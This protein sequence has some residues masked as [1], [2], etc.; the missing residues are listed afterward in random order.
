MLLDGSGS[1]SGDDWAVQVNGLADAVQD[2]SCFPQ[3]G[4]VELSVIQFSSSTI[5]HLDPTIV[6]SGN[7]ATVVAAIQDADD[8]Q[9]N[10][11]TDLAQGIDR[12][13]AT[14]QQSPNFQE[15][16]AQ[17]MNISTDGNPDSEPAAEQSRD[18]AVEVFDEIDAEAVGT[19]SFIPWMRDEIVFPQ[20]GTA[21][22][23]GYDAWPPPGPGW[24]RYVDGFEEYAET[25]CEKFQIIV[26]PEPPPEPP[27]PPPPP[28]EAPFVPEAST[29]ILLGS[30]VSG[31]AGYV[32]LQ[33]RARRKK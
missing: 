23:T 13:L 15:A 9:L 11:G 28:A 32:G 24:V 7:I 25:L 8:Q 29:L 30:G 22:G 16:D 26:P 2:E 33:W 4:S 10:G 18:I 12:S 1:I 6:T 14:V 31:L 19:T 5:T 3:D 27:P 17:I 20:P 21:H